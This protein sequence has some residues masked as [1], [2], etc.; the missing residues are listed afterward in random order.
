MPEL[1]NAPV[2]FG[3]IAITCLISLYA[4]NDPIAKSKMLFFPAR[5]HGAPDAYRFVSH[6]FIHADYMHLIF[7]MLTLYFFGTAAEMVIFQKYTYLIFYVSA[8]VASSVYDFIRHR[9][10]YNYA[11]LGASGAVSA[12]VFSTILLHPWMK[13]VCLYGAI[14]I[15]NIIYGV[16]YIVYCIYMDKQGRDNIGHSAHLWGA[17][18]GIVF[19]ALIRPD[20]LLRFLEELT[21]PRF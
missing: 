17:I 16:L 1:L 15:P 13:G 9:N 20:I 4:M 2:T 7:N 18:Y 12:V 6:G 5:M 11:A 14:C 10:N 8:L 21:H 3:I 19:T